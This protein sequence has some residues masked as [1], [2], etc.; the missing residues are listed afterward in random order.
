MFQVMRNID[1]LF[2]LIQLFFSDLNLL[3]LHIMCMPVCDDNFNNT[4]MLQFSKYKIMY[5]V[6]QTL[7][8]GARAS[9]NSALTSQ[10]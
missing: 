9:E 1:G 4:G 2:K 7:K 10:K 6:L 8:T 5:F 3:I